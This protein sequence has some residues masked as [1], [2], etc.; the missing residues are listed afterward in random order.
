MQGTFKIQY[1]FLYI[2]ELIYSIY[3]DHGYQKITGMIVNSKLNIPD[4]FIAH[5]VL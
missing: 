2:S 5:V 1:K 3:L 4:I